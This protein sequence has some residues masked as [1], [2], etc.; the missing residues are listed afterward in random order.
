MEDLDK[1]LMED[2]EDINFEN[3]EKLNVDEQTIQKY[4][5][6]ESKRSRVSKRS[7]SGKV[8][9]EKDDENKIDKKLKVLEDY[10]S[11]RSNTSSRNKKEREE[12]K[13]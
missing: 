3:I 13:K 5:Q 10:I 7:N 8:R 1:F 12:N 2:N 6:L 11:Q 9:G 4:L